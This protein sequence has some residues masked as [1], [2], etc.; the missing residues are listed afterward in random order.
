MISKGLKITLGV[1]LAGVGI[2]V[3]TVLHLDNARLRKNLVGAEQAKREAVRLQDE[4][5]HARAQLSKMRAS[6]AER[7]E[8][9]TRD[10][11]RLRR[12][13]ADLEKAAS[14]RAGAA[15]L[16]AQND[17]RAKAEGSNP[18]TGLTPLERFHDVGQANPA[19][20]FQTF[21]WAAMQGGDEKLASMIA[22]NGSG[23]AAAEAVVAA[24]PEADRAKFPTPEKLAALFFADAFT[25]MQ[26]AQ[27]VDVAMMDDRSAVVVVR[28]MTRREQKIPM[29]LGPAGWQIAIPEGMARGLEG[30]VRRKTGGPATK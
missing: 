15:R 24:L 14:A 12:E 27:I 8:T 25:A 4:N 13:V 26:A 7:A 30:W 6:E 9:L 21:V 22:F 28:G 29:Q 16:Q 5:D 10:A 23:R 17:A 18:E 19:A 2:F 20:A 1:L 3:A 11:E